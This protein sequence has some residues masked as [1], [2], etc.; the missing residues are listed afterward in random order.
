SIALLFVACLMVLFFFVAQGLL[1][2]DFVG[3]WIQGKINQSIPGRLVW[4]STRVDLAQGRLELR[5]LLISEPSGRPVVVVDRLFLDLEWM[6][7]F[8]K[9]LAISDFRIENPHIRLERDQAGALDLVGAFSSGEHTEKSLE[10]PAGFAL[11]FNPV[12]KSFQLTGGKVS[13]RDE[14]QQTEIHVSR[15]NLDAEGNLSGKTAKISMTGVLD[16]SRSGTLTTHPGEFSLAGG[17]EQ[18]RITDVVF[19]IDFPGLSAS[20]EGAIQNSWQ[21]PA[22]NMDL[23]IQASLEE[24]SNTLGL[25][26]GFS[27]SSTLKGS[28]SGPLSNPDAGFE[29]D[30]RGGILL[31]R[32]VESIKMR[33]TLQDRIATLN[34]LDIAAQEGESVIKGVM[35]LQKAFPKGFLG[36][37][38]EVDRIDH[39]YEVTVKKC[40]IG[41]LVKS[42]NLLEGDLA[43]SAKITGKGIHPSHITGSAEFSIIAENVVMERIKG[44]NRLSIKGRAAKDPKGR[45]S[46]NITASTTGV[47]LEASGHLDLATGNL[48]AKVGAQAADL[49]PL[50]SLL[51]LEK[52]GGSFSLQADLSGSVKKPALNLTLAG[53]HL[54]RENLSLEDLK[55]VVKSNKP[56]YKTGP[57]LDWSITGKGFKFNGLRLDGV[58]SQGSLNDGMLFL[59]QVDLMGEKTLVHMNGAVRLLEPGSFRPAG[60]PSGNLEI[61]SKAFFLEDF[62]QDAK[63]RF[64]CQARVEGQLANLKG[65]VKLEGADILIKNQSLESVS[66]DA[67]ILKD[68]MVFHP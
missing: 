54:T 57:N 31:S 10:K 66:L 40:K 19:K 32:A 44:R 36:P 35:N 59:K 61:L 50:A 67:D 13:F 63:G 2:S 22:I 65:F 27:G 4:K 18:D 56:G 17:V 11:P 14:V 16:T 6:A 29:L 52:A 47:D 23:L 5:N 58:E 37:D 41:S 43:A 55:F 68:R 45:L 49:L 21:A 30:Y 48:A 60:K 42:G 34:H 64:S 53:S 20:L 28:V 26:G 15:L 25:E 24:L 12:L 46:A 51:G 1:Q 3:G 62:M 7:L 38:K 9:N 33:L 8:K 39:D